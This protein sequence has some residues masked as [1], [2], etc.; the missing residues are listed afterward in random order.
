M[1][2]TIDM[3][4]EPLIIFKQTS[5][6]ANKQTSKQANKQTSK[7]ANKQTSAKNPFGREALPG[8]TYKFIISIPFPK[9][10]LQHTSISHE[11]SLCVVLFTFTNI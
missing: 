11:I 4:K 8:N 6:Q 1:V 2:Y 7:Q 9:K 5:K 3:D 10:S